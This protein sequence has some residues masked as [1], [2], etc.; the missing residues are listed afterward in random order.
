MGAFGAPIY[1]LHFVFRLRLAETGFY[2]LPE[3]NPRFAFEPQ[4]VCRFM[5]EANRLPAVSAFAEDPVLTR[6]RLAVGLF[7]EDR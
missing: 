2:D 5:T 3:A 7:L 6:Y 4:H 1:L